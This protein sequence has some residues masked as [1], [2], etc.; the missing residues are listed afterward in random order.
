[1]GHADR[2]E[3]P[4]DSNPIAINRDREGTPHEIETRVVD[5]RRPVERGRCDACRTG[6]G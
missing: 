1:V 3:R 6:R 4:A 5:R 2:I